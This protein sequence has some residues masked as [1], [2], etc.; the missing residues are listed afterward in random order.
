MTDRIEAEPIGSAD[1]R[2]LLAFWQEKRHAKDG[3][4]PAR[5]DLRPEAMKPFLP[6]VTLISVFEA[7]RRFQFR[8]VGTGVLAHMGRETT[9]VWV[10]HE[11]F[12]D[13]AARVG[14]F[15]SL[16]VDTGAPAYARGSYAVTPSNRTLRFETVIMPLSS[17]GTTIDMLLGGLVGEPLAP[18]ERVKAFDY[19]VVLP[20][21]DDAG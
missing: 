4:L 5:A 3:R 16:P 20:I 14:E 13:K 12:A 7:P 15:F 8:L 18:G 2:A 6:C 1:L 21:A 9:H 19:E 11:L 17:D 10:E